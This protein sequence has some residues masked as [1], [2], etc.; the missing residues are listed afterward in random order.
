MNLT[1]KKAFVTGAAHGIGRGCALELA[2][3]GADV[4]V[5]D[6][7]QTAQGET[8]VAAVQAL[9][10]QSILIPGDV[11]ERTSCQTIVRRQSMFSD[12]STFSSATQ[13]FSTALSS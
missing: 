9:G 8:I 5:N 11:F 10:R 13:P 6:R 4:V 2:R 3:A 1:G 7:E 12:K